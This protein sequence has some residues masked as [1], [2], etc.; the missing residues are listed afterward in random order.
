M[1]EKPIKD[2]PSL[3]KFHEDAQN[4]LALKNEW[5]SLRPLFKV[6]GADVEKIDDVL[7]QVE[8]LVE[9]TNELTSLP[10]EFNDLFS[11]KG[12]IMYS[13]MN[14]DLARKAIELGNS[15]KLDEAERILIE[16]YSP[17]EVQRELK[18]MIS[19][20]AFRIRIP[21]AE[22]ALIDFKEERFYS[23]VLVVLSLLDGMVNEIIHKGF[24]AKDVDLTA[25]DSVAAHSKGLQKLISVMSKSRTLT[26]IDTIDIPYRNGIMHG[27]DLGYDNRAVAVKAWVALFATRDW[28]VKAERNQIEAPPEKPEKTWKEVFAQWQENERDKKA[29][30]NWQSRNIIIGKTVTIYGD[31]ADYDDNTP[32][33]KL[34]EFF[35]Y[36]KSDN[37]GFMAK[38]IHSQTGDPVNLFPRYVREEYYGKHLKSWQ[39]SEIED[40]SPA[41]TLISVSASYEEN[42]LTYT[43]LL[44]ARM[45]LHDDNNIVFIR[46]KPGSRWSLVSWHLNEIVQSFPDVAENPKQNLNAWVNIKES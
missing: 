22:K 4:F 12:W 29:I 28:A 43:K 35:H 32:E 31:P 46:G 9:K 42:E 19:V 38:C 14:I 30:E 36:W 20:E 3:K 39:L 5:P 15:G 17:E 44:Q 11:E 27:M 45:I 18:S 24:F 6:L 13:R 40:V 26:V 34:S 10:D 1:E 8:P 21:L 23:T 16:F 37:Y 25:W 7:R 41:V 33:R 2:I